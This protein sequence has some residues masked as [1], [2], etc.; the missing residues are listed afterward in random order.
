MTR[1]AQFSRAGLVEAAANLA[2]RNGPAAVTISSV[3]E[4]AGAPT[5]SV[6]HRFDS[7][8]ELM[9]AAWLGAVASF[10]A[11]F[12]QALQAPSQP[13][14]LEAALFAVRWTRAQAVAARLVILYRRQDFFA[15]MPPGLRAE[16]E[17]LTAELDEALTAFARDSLGGGGLPA[18]ERAAFLLIDL[19]YAAVRRHLAAGINPPPGVEDLVRE[20]FLAMAPA[21]VESD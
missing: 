11:G 18:K 1:P 9:A 8:A 19:P 21:S 4:H 2:A 12:L 16:A 15:T 14:G 10:Q 5:G 17:T 20:A 7:R 6:Y 3:A 13:P